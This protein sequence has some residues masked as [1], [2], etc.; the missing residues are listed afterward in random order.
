M[1]QLALDAVF[2]DPGQPLRGFRD[3]SMGLGA[4]WGP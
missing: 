2:M 4:C 1:P 3:D